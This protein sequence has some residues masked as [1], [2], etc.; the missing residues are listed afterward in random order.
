MD[1]IDFAKIEEEIRKEIAD[2][3]DI[4]IV[5]FNNILIDRDDMPR[6]NTL[7][8]DEAVQKTNVS[9]LLKRYREIPNTG[10][11]KII[12]KVIRKTVDLYTGPIIEDQNV[13]NENVLLVL[14]LLY[15]YVGQNEKRIAKLEKQIETLQ[16]ENKLL[17]ENKIYKE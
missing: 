6:W 11:K 17:K 12:K 1:V 9:A 15:D 2:K 14:N 13:Y 10:I 4:D 3:R 16:N 7:D 5:E 8:F